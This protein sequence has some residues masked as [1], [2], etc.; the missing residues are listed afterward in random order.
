MI[1]QGQERRAN[2][3]RIGAARRQMLGQLHWMKIRLKHLSLGDLFVLLVCVAGIGIAI[4]LQT[5]RHP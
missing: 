3:R 5:L 1:R 4:Y 2:R